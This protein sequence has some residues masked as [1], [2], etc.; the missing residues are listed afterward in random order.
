[1]DEGLM[2]LLDATLCVN[3][4]QRVFLGDDLHSMISHPIPCA[5]MH[6]LAHLSTVGT[7]SS[8]AE[9]FVSSSLET[10]INVCKLQLHFYCCKLL[11]LC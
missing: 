1:M 9:I 6:Q 11:L 5:C 8:S 7:Y 10:A 2:S 3:V 4:K